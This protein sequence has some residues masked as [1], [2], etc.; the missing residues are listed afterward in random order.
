MKFPVIKHKMLP[1]LGVIILL[2]LIALM[3]RTGQ[4]DDEPLLARVQRRNIEIR[5]NSVGDLDAEKSHLIA[6]ELRGDSGKIVYL[7][8]DG[9]WVKQGDILVR[10]DRTPFEET[11]TTLKGEIEIEKTIVNVAE[12]LLNSEK[13]QVERRVKVAGFEATSA[14]IELNKLEKGEGPLQLAQYQEAVEQARDDLTKNENFY[15]ELKVLKSQGYGNDR[16][17]LQAE[18]KLVQYRKKF[19]IAED[20]FKSYSNYVFP[21][22]MEK[23]RAKVSQSN[24]ELVLTK[25]EGGFQLGKAMADLS[26]AQQKLKNSREK[27]A[28]AMNELEKTVVK[29]PTPGICILY[30]SF[31]NSEKRKPRIGDTIWQNRPILYLPDISSFIVKTRAREIDLHKISKNQPVDIKI[32]A[33]PDSQLHGRIISIGALAEQTTGMGTERSFNMV[34]AIDGKDERL[35]PGMT[36]SLSVLSKQ[37]NNILTVPTTAIYREKEAAYCYRKSGSGYVMTP[38]KIG[39][40]NNNYVEIKS[41]LKEGDQVSMAGPGAAR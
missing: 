7:V 2:G 17:L 9:D 37:L 22:E 21:A 34:V 11:I 18:K 26:R 33:Y 19:Q 27:L 12:Q 36:A 31:F 20:K 35:R 16:E 38:V 28:I 1:I 4:S 3:L 41:G 10:F 14:G 32:D 6:S 23:C 5:L 24:M 40:M 39:E 30:E 15:N 29:A 8:Q 13:N 25:K